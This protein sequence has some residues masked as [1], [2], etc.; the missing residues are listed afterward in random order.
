MGSNCT[1]P[2]TH[3]LFPMNTINVFSFPYDFLSDI[4]FSL[5]SFFIVRTQIY[6]AY[7]YKIR[8]NQLLMLPVRFPVNSK[9]LVVKFEGKF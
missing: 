9:L 4:F 1:G 7:K 2:L 3:R 6:N 8:V 5:A